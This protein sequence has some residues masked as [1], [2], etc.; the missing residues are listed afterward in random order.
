MKKYVLALT[1]IVS[2]T[3]S[4]RA[5]TKVMFLFQNLP[6]EKNIQLNKELSLNYVEQGSPNGIPVVFLHGYSDSWHSYESV[7]PHLPKNIHAFVVTQRGHGNSGKPASGYA[8][9]DFASDIALFVKKLGIGPVI[10]VGHSLGG[11]VA[12]RFVIDY[13]EL[14]RSLVIIASTSNF[15]SN[16]TV[17]EFEKEV[18]KLSDPIDSTFASEFQKATITKPVDAEYFSRLVDESRKL[19]AR[20]WKDIIRELMK[21]DLSQE[22]KRISKPTLIFWGDQDVFCSRAHQDVLE[23]SIRGSKLLIYEGTGHAIHWEEPKRFTNDL[24]EFINKNNTAKF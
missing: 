2:A 12:Q 4:L 20:I 7:L 14:T 6:V 22:I 9:K 8:P 21:Q 19:P 10:I 3:I 11:V 16:E 15:A 23:K 5:Q 1:L 17:K 18:M 24:I 13:P